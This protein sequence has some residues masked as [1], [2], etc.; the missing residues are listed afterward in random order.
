MVVDN[1]NYLIL[2]LKKIILLCFLI[3]KTWHFKTFLRI[4]SNMI[5]IM[6]SHRR[7]GLTCRN[8][9]LCRPLPHPPPTKTRNIIEMET[10]PSPCEALWRA[11]KEI[12]ILALS[13]FF[14]L[15]PFLNFFL[16]FFF[17]FFFFFLKIPIYLRDGVMEVEKTHVWSQEFWSLAPTLGS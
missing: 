12:T 5:H 1:I 4:L 9:A 16:F 14:F 2:P 3:L 17:S 6:K 10:G 11:N 15:P 7:R 8:L 13:F